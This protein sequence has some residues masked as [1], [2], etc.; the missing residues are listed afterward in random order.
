MAIFAIKINGKQRAW[1]KKF[2]DETGFEPDYQE[3]IDAGTMTFDE[4]AKYNIDWFEN[5]SGDV[6]SRVSTNV[7]YTYS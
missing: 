3:E 4:V 7:P 1:L 2:E 6:H 5:W